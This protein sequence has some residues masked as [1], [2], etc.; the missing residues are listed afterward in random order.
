MLFKLSN[1]NSNLA[2]TLSYLN[3]ALNKSAL[4]CKPLIVPTNFKICLLS[5]FYILFVSTNEQEGA[6]NVGDS[7]F[8]DKL[9]ELYPL[10]TVADPDQSSRPWDKGGWGA[11]GLKKIVFWPF[12]PQFGLKIR[13]GGAFPGSA[14]EAANRLHR[15]LDFFWQCVTVYAL[16]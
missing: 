5:N 15:L 16:P 4:R 13:G 10:C 9:L 7:F 6:V 3:P 8:S 1:L 12:R 14:S 11:G 2:L